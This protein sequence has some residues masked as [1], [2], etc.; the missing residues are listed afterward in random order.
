MNRRRQE[1]LAE[2]IKR[3]LSMIIKD[4]KDPRVDFTRVSVTRVE[5]TNDLSHA[6]IYISIL[7]NEAEQKEI[8]EVIQ[9][10]KGFI[11]SRLAS[12]IQLRHAPDIDLR[13]DKSIEHGIRISS[14][15]NE[16]NKREEKKQE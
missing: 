2:E 5:L 15:L 1:R 10:A 6:R 9:K 13:L 3:T 14:L 7:G 11:R 12:E 4:L 16:I 8:M